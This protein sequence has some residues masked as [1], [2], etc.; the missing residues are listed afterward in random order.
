MS[1]YRQLFWEGI[2]R[3][4]TKASRDQLNCLLGL[5]LGAL[6]CLEQAIRQKLNEIEVTD[7]APM[8]E[9]DGLECSQAALASSQPPS[10]GVSA[11]VGS[12]ILAAPADIPTHILRAV[13]SALC[14][15]DESIQREEGDP[16]GQAV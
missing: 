14:E 16:T 11:A 15:L 7:K 5:W 6:E 12:R 8:D 4:V 3:I 9:T 1:C 10:G 2:L 13:Y